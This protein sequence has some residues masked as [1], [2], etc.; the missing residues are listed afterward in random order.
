MNAHIFVS[1]RSTHRCVVIGFCSDGT[2]HGPCKFIEDADTDVL[3]DWLRRRNRFR[4]QL[5]RSMFAARY[6]FEFSSTGALDIGMMYNARFRPIHIVED[7]PIHT[8][9]TDPLEYRH[10]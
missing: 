3:V 2:L 10:L 6:K 4:M 8:F 5:H 1:N 7:E 9:W